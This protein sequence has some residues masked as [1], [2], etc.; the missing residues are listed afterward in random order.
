VGL[1]VGGGHGLGTTLGPFESRV[2]GIGPQLNCFFPVTDNIQ[3]VANVKAYWD[4][5]A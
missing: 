1:V 5:A 3:G 2:A 4:F